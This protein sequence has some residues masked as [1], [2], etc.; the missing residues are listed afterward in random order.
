M[1]FGFDRGFTDHGETPVDN[2][3]I[4]E[5]LPAAEGDAVRV[6]LY[7][8]MRCY[9]PDADMSMERMA[10]ELGMEEEEI[11]RAYRYWERRGLVHRLSDVP[12]AWE[13]VSLRENQKAVISEVDREYELFTESLYEVFNN[14]RRLHGSEIN[15]CYEWVEELKLPR[16]AVIMLLKHMQNI[17]GKNFS[18]ASAQKMAIQMAEDGVRTLED[19]EAFLSRDQALY[20]GTREVLRRLGRKNNPSEDQMNLYRKWTEDWK[21]THEA[22]LEA[23]AETAK[24]DPNMGYLDGILRKLRERT[25]GTEDTIDGNAVQRDRQLAE[26]LKK[27]LDIL[28]RG[29]VNPETL[30]WYK[31]LQETAS[32]GMILLAARECARRNGTP[33]DVDK[34]L[35]SWQKKGIH[36]PEEAE[37]YIQEFNA[38][39][40]LLKELREKWGLTKPMGEKDRK[41]VSSWTREMG[42][43]REMILKTA[44]FAADSNKPMPYLDKILRDFSEQGIRTPEQAERER[45]RYHSGTSNKVGARGV[46]AQQYTQRDYSQE[47]ETL[48]Q[49]MARL[50]G[51]EVPHA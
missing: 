13:Y 35:K 36:T 34:M 26:Q 30:A 49:M 6:Y 33:E 47:T 2:R 16:E 39:S 31:G 12:L 20:H 14:Q 29:H 21:F 9:Y 37:N 40:A 23:C 46:P 7:G 17:K 51:G 8:L 44:E 41:L 22:I 42:F 45:A 48:D 28:G 24:G 3:F 5:Y 32:E 18:I 43:D 1:M 15:I 19:A 25:A 27:M 10:A 50:N 11:K 38:Q 4:Q